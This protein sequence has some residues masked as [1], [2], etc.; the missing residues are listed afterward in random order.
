M[1][2]QKINCVYTY[3]YV[4]TYMCVHIYISKFIKFDVN[5]CMKKFNLLDEYRTTR[6]YTFSDKYGTL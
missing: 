6:E 3:I 1:V 5:N 4:H 2:Q